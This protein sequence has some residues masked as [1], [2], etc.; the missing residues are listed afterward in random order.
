GEAVVSRHRQHAGD[1]ND[2]ARALPGAAMRALGAGNVHGGPI[3]RDDDG[4][5]RAL[6]IKRSAAGLPAIRLLVLISVDD[7][8]LE[9]AVLIINAVAEAGHAKRGE[10]FEK[11][12]G[13]A[14]E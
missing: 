11:A 5:V 9:E 1:P 3:H 12:C 13:E 6:D 7:L 10:R 14:P 2:H 4:F 8:L